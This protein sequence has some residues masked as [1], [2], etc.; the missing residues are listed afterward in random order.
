MKS[1]SV[2][3]KTVWLY[4][5]GIFSIIALYYLLIGVDQGV[6]VVIQSGEYID[7]PG[8]FV[9]LAVI[10]MSYLVWYSSRML[11]YIKQR[12][13]YMDQKPNPISTFLHQHFPRIISF[14]CY[15]C[16]QAAIVSLP[17]LYNWNGYLLLGFILFHNVLYFLITQWFENRNRK[18]GILGLI[19]ILIYGFVFISKDVKKLDTE[20]E[21]VRHHQV[22]LLILFAVLFLLEM[23][24]IFLLVRRRKR[25][26]K[27]RDEDVL[28][29]SSK[30]M[31]SQR[32]TYFSI[33]KTLDFR[34]DFIN[35]EKTFVKCFGI[36][37]LIVMLVY[38][39]GIFNNSTAVYIGT[40]AY[41]L[42]ALGVLVSITNFISFFSIK[43]A[44]NLFLILLIWSIA[45]GKINDP[46]QVRTLDTKADFSYNDRPEAKDY[47]DLW[48][49]NRIELM[50]THKSYAS[51][52]VKFDVYIVLSNGGASRAGYWASYNMCKLQDISYYKDPKNSFKEHLLCLAG[53]SGGTVG[54]ASFYALLK[55]QQDK[56][57][58]ESQLLAD[59]SSSFFR[60]DF[61]VFPIAHLLGP[62][63]LQ[64]VIPMK[65]MDDRG[66]ALE[67]SFSESKR[68]ERDSIKHDTLLK[69]YFKRP[70]SEVFDQSGA[71]PVFYMNT[72]EVDNG[73]PG[74]ISN[75]KLASVEFTSRRTDVL[76]LVDS[77]RTTQNKKKDIRFSTASILSSRF[78]YVSPAGKV[79][80]RYF[81][82]GGYFDNSGAG[83]IFE[84]TQQLLAF[85][86]TKQK[87]IDSA[88]YKR[89]T[90]HI[91]HFN[92]SDKNIKPIKNINPVANDLASP[93]LTLL[94][95]QGA[96]TSATDGVLSDYFEESFARHE[97]RPVRKDKRAI[98]YSL[99]KDPDQCAEREEVY[100]MSW[101]LSEYQIAR[102]KKAFVR[103]NAQ[104]LNKFYFMG[105]PRKQVNKKEKL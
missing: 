90:F 76:A 49:K 94:G 86:D 91:I 21:V 19:L 35:A 22:S 64:H 84:F 46:Y 83:T 39:A 42:L 47:L 20:L 60:K 61:L 71:L 80:N 103:E 9:L 58:K 18:M 62:D 24:W 32:G 105:V 73:A 57:I 36:A 12:K 93:F 70:L 54:N 16:L 66:D 69:W 67:R 25:V 23:I 33:M 48:F 28:K 6:D 56:K 40:L 15:V 37:A 75:M 68:E 41:V 98:E 17:T 100:P 101:V 95:I 77:L 26:D 52:D 30:A 79:H 53:A 50:K 55:A 99:Y 45:T 5:G 31:E 96:N 104:N 27:T 87:G 65:F 89:F 82:D 11:S 81:V 72:T 44:V 38:L 10:L 92:N 1:L 78:P 43:W 29:S 8:L 2:V 97:R 63:L 85:L 74:V 34:S 51:K 14:N 4:A 102:M 88:Y 59:Y 3:L 13:E 7:G